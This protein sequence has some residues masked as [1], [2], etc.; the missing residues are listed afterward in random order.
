MRKIL[1]KTQL[2]WCNNCKENSV[3][4]EVRERKADNKRVRYAYCLN[5]GCGYRIAIDIPD[6]IEDNNCDKY[7]EY[8][9]SDCS[10]GYCVRQDIPDNY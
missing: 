1:T 8:T 7:C 5:K 3:K 10:K 9:N 2:S 4:I 6:M